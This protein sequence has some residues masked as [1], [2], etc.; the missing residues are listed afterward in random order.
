MQVKDL[1]G[2]NVLVKIKDAGELAGKIVGI[3]KEHDASD[4]ERAINLTI[5]SVAFENG[6][7]ADV[8]GYGFSK[9]DNA[10]YVKESTTQPTVY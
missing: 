10:A 7:R 1:V 3:A 5:F 6:G 9:I 2:S 4:I 8:S